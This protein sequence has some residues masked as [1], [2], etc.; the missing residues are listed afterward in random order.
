M[1]EKI[2]SS[3]FWSALNK[4]GYKLVSFVVFIFLARLL[5]PQAFGLVALT[6]I[7]IAFLDIFVQQGL[8]EAIIQKK[9]ISPVHLD[10]VFWA[11]L[12]ISIIFFCA[13]V[14]FAPFIGV[15]FDEPNITNLV[16]VLSFL[17]VVSA[18]KCVQRALLAKNFKFKE[19]TEA[20]LLGIAIGGIAGVGSA[21]Y[22]LGAWALVIFQ[23]VSK[24]LDALYLW[25]VSSWRPKARF[26]FKYF[27]EMFTFGMNIIGSRILS[28][29]NKYLADF[30]IGFFLGTTALG[31]YNVAFRIIRSLVSLIGGVINDAGLPTF[32]SM[33]DDFSKGERSY[34]KISLVASSISVPLF[35]SIIYFSDI[36][37]LKFFGDKW[38]ESIAIMRILGFIGILQSLYYLNNAVITGY[39]KP[40][41]RFYLDALNVICNGIAFLIAVN[42]GI[43]AVAIAYVIRAYI[44]SPLPFIVVKKILSINFLDYFNHLLPSITC[45]LLG[46]FAVYITNIVVASYAIGD[47]VSLI[48]GSLLFSIVYL[49]SFSLIFAQKKQ[50]IVEAFKGLVVLKK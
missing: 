39:G 43:K 23:L 19:L 37:I 42:W 50:F 31:V 7:Y 26:V 41:W 22:G 4:W 44:L 13:S 11:N 18:F 9:D 12:G 17:L 30:I 8:G 35:A 46:I 25:L 6:T 38:F 36:I 49:L 27:I 16:K 33:Q 10:T 1:K 15:I 20:S 47:I 28:F 5:D 34:Y 48:I 24:G 32:S 2:R 45:S 14:L 21:I 40:R 3:F 29:S